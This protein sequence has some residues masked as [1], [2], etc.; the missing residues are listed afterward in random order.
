M[1]LSSVVM[2]SPSYG[3][4]AETYKKAVT[5]AATAATYT[6]L[7]RSMARELLPDEVRDTVRWA[8]SVVRAHILPRP[9]QRRV[10]TIYIS[11][12]TGD[13]TQN[14]FYADARA[15]L[16]TRIDPQAMGELCLVVRGARRRLSMVPGDSMTDVFEGVEF[17]WTSTRRPRR[18]GR[19]GDDSTSDDEDGGRVPA[20]SL[21]LCFDA[22]QMDLALNK[23]PPFITATVGEERRR[24]C[25]INIV[26]NVGSSWHGITHHHPAT[27]DTL[28]MDPELKRTLVA[29][30]DR[31][32]K[33]RD[34][35][36]R[37][38]KAWK[39]G[40][41]L[42]G[43]PGTGKSSLV[44]AMAIYLHFNLFDLD[45][46]DVHSNSTLQKLLMG[47]NNKSNLVIEDIDC[48]FSAATREEKSDDSDSDSSD[49]GKVRS[50]G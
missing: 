29:D 11:R 8:A 15:Y 14:H 28:A 9:K 46:S 2:S 23:Y 21:V 30:L 41:L 3:K 44:A 6:V 48:C 22:E 12:Y 25:A 50:S 31:F 27:F 40:Y 45:L 17:K 19:R 35:Y 43:P 33:R 39:S 26:M 32:L 7:A 16:E 49:S 18:R 47:L 38:G 13:G 42:Y 10:K 20:D 37:I 34:Y 24:R 4:A 36:R 5:V 1:D